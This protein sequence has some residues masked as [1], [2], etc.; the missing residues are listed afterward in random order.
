MKV[1]YIAD[2]G[3]KIKKP[4][5]KQGLKQEADLL[6]SRLRQLDTRAAKRLVESR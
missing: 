2:I 1:V 5:K 4:T 3:P 6:A